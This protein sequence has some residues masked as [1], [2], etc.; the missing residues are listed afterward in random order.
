MTVA[1]K[2][3]AIAEN[4]QKVYDAGK[5]RGYSEGFAD[6]TPQT[7]KDGERA[8]SETF[9]DYLTNYGNRA[10]YRA[11]FNRW[12]GETFE[13]TR[14]IIPRESESSYCTFNDAQ[15]LKKLEAKY[16]DFSKKTRGTGN[17]GGYYYTFYN[18]LDL[19]EI[20]DIGMQADINYTHA[21]SSCKDLH[22][23]AK[24]RCDEATTFSNTFDFCA[25][26]KNV[27]FEGDI[28]QDINLKWSK[29]LSADSITNIIEHL[30]DTAQ[31]KTLTLSSA[32]VN[33][34]H[35]GDE[36]VYVTAHSAIDCQWIPCCCIPLAEGERLKVT[37]EVEDGHHYTDHDWSTGAAEGEWF[38]GFS[39]ECGEPYHRE[40]IF[41]Y[42]DPEIS[43]YGDGQVHLTVYVITGGAVSFKFKVRAVK[44]DG[45]GNE[46]DGENLYSVPNGDYEFNYG[47][48]CTLATG[49][50][51][52]LVA[53][54]PNW[55][56]SLI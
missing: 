27:T 52:A 9:W 42:D 11:V 39:N 7:Y 14:K 46:I 24:I 47:G 13:P 30:S 36:T 55:T 51:E 40:K 41:N 53:S 48:S 8:A 33:D 44:I 5:R 32:E 29:N 34:V 54:K 49:G 2:L 18:C 21:F 37:L 31:G 6:G 12:G 56:I 23:I 28:G 25:A 45:D 3:T 17:H 16:I 26:L 15:K 19:Q 1:Q 38:V 43:P 22:T 4:E 10:S 35:T 50:W 20:E